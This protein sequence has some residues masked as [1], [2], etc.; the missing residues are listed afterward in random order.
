M[1][2]I[3]EFED[4]SFNIVFTIIFLNFDLEWKHSYVCIIFHHTFIVLI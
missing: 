1:V 4:I 3:S 2:G